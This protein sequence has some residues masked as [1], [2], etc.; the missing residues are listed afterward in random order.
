VTL[1]HVKEVAHAQ[2]E[3]E[4]KRHQ[5]E[6]ELHIAREQEGRRL[7]RELVAA[8]GCL[9]PAHEGLALEVASEL[10]A[11]ELQELFIGDARTYE[12]GLDRLC[13]WLQD[14]VSCLS[15]GHLE[16]GDPDPT[17]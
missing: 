14:L 1:V 8:Q 12:L 11:D 5:D 7:V 17:L 9:V 15:V 10:L 3:F 16:V 4:R 2:L 6:L 13:H